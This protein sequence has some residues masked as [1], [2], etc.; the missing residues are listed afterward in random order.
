MYKWRK[1]DLNIKEFI[2]K[3]NVGKKLKI[4]RPS[5]ISFGKKGVNPKS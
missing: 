2:A 3:M 4:W 1:A 5:K